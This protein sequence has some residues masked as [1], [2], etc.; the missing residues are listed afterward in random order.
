M[1]VLIAP[2]SFDGTLTANQASEAIVE[3]WRRHASGDELDVCPLTDGGAG[4]VDTLHRTLGGDLVPLTVTGPLGEPVPATLLLT[5]GPEG[6]TAYVEAAQACGQH[7]VPAARR[8]P[9]ATTTAGVGDLLLAALASN[10]RRVVVGVGGTAT[11]DGGAGALAALGAG[12]HDALGRGGG[13]LVD[14]PDDALAGLHRVRSRF[15]HV[16]LVVA[17]DVDVPLLGFKGTAAITAE[18]KGASKQQAQD[19]DRALGRFAQVALQ[20]LG[21]ERAPQRL[22]ATPGLGAGGGLAFSL[23]LL[24]GRSGGGAA[25]AA[26]AVDLAGRLAGCDLVVTGEGCFDWASLRGGVVA[27]V[28]EEALA[29]GVPVVVVAGQV[30][31]GRRESL[32]IGVESAYAVAERPE[33]VDGALADPA[34]TLAARVERVA[35]T[36]SR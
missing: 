6:A 24:G 23:A 19:L 35:R 22:V 18:G 8:D 36:W 21:E 9:A 17:T 32:S 29:L 7:L 5:R 34:G 13:P 4:F 30:E 12:S 3:G 1:R 10:P 25:V 31:V 15:A 28:A 2:D 33:Q 11:V 14:L 27:T 16:D 26:D 20:T